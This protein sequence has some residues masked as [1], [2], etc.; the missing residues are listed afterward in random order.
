MGFFKI[1]GTEYEGWGCQKCSVFID[2]FKGKRM[3]EMRKRLHIQQCNVVKE[4]VS[5][6]EQE[7]MN[8]EHFLNRMKSKYPLT[9][10]KP[11]NKEVFYYN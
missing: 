8:K 7:K 4:N 6:E 5:I 2:D 3:F 9:K 11:N 1:K 10:E